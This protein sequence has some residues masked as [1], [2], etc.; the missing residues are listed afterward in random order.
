[1]KNS[2]LADLAVDFASPVPVYEQIKK[3]IKQ[4]IA[5]SI[6]QEN[7]P[8]PSIREL[9]AFLRINPNTVARAYRDLTQEQI[10]SGRAGIGFW[11][12]KPQSP[13][14]G[15][16]EM[17]REEMLKFMEK[18]IEM[19][20]TRQQLQELIDNTFAES[21]QPTKGNPRGE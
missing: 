13:D 14:Q 8:L 19:G 11:V 17:L 6:L 15:K 16:K 20:F 4:A 10:I 18:G 3:Q 7:Q 2:F 9:A 12:A 1:M 5:R 21:R